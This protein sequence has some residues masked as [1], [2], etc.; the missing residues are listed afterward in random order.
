VTH[1]LILVLVVVGVAYYFMTED[2]RTR[3]L[4]ALKIR[5]RDGL[6]AVTFQG[7]GC[8]SFFNFLRARTR[9]L[10][11]T[12]SLVVLSAVITLA[13]L[14]GTHGKSWHLVAVIFGYSRVLE[15]IIGTVCVLQLGLILERLLGR[16]A[17]TIIYVATGAAAGIISLALFPDGVNIGASGSVL[18]LYG[19]LVV[20]STWSLIYPSVVSIPLVVAKRLAP[21]AAVFVVYHWITSDFGNAAYIAAFAVGLIGG[22]LVAR[23]VN[24]NTPPIRP[25]ATAMGVGLAIVTVFSVVVMY[26]PVSPITDVRPEI[27]R[28][29]AVEH[30]TAGL[31]NDAIA[32][33]RK[34]RIDREALVDLIQETIMPELHT[35]SARLNALHGVRPEDR[36]LVATVEEFL[37]LRDES[38]RLRAAALLN[39]D[40]IGLR[41]ADSKEQASLEALH[42]IKTRIS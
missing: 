22:I 8:D 29:I 21:V 28:V 11:A 39:G 1:F 15:L 37:K 27:Q 40:I 35:L 5:L 32:T 19:V 23:D 20:T 4:Q 41:K 33:F 2:E 24:Y 17:F 38:W 36:P 9:R 3:V 25:L 26:R 14:G 6:D 7:L 16:L 12:P 34:G 30:R 18:G 13:G 10:T 42:R 31:Y